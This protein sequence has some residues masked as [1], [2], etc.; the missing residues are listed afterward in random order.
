MNIIQVYKRYPKHSDCTQHLERVRWPDGPRCPYCK[1]ARIT[2]LPAQLRHHCN[3]CNTSFSVTVQTIFHN[4]KLD[5]QKWFLAI[6]LILNAKKGLSARQLAQDIEVNKNTAWYMGMRIRKA[7]EDDGGLLRSIVENDETHVGGKPRKGI[8]RDGDGGLTKH[9]CGR[10]TEKT[11]VVGAVERNGS[12]KAKV[13]T[14]LDA[15]HLTALVRCHVDLT[16]F[17]IMTDEYKGYNRL[18]TMTIHKVIN[19]SRK[20]VNGEIH[21]NT[22]EGYWA[23]LKRGIAGQYHKVSLTNLQRYINEFAFRH[24]NRQNADV[25]D[26]MICK[27]VGV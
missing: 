17:T 5:L 16:Q 1:S 11:P 13:V 22:I 26:L 18:R 24:N 14:W 21:T 4:S 8:K 2:A 10:G 3:G 12:V 27:V 23:L 20:Y 25:F 15:K 6:A 7:L 9:L 19:H